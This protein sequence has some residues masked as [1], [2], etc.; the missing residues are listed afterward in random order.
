MPHYANE[1]PC[2]IGDVVKGPYG[3]CTIIGVV[4]RIY[5]SDTCNMEIGHGILIHEDG[6]R[7]IV[8]PH[9]H[10][11]CTVTCKEFEKIA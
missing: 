4:T 11:S 9:M 2:Q 1:S 10:S 5:A 7:R 3:C 6:E 8:M